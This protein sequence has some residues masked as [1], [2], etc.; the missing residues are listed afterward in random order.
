MDPLRR[1]LEID[2]GIKF[3]YV[4]RGSK[5]LLTDAQIRRGSRAKRA[6]KTGNGLCAEVQG[7][8]CFSGRKR[9]TLESW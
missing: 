2:V 6:A 8:F 1:W 7:P 5:H 3:P 9:R 4:T